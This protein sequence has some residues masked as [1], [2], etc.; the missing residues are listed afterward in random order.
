MDLQ[1]LITLVYFGLLAL[2]S[3]CGRVN[4]SAIGHGT[5]SWLRVGQSGLGPREFDLCQSG[6]CD[7]VSCRMFSPS[8]HSILWMFHQAPAQRVALSWRQA[9]TLPHW[10]GLSCMLSAAPV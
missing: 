10:S 6:S 7:A 9:F 4:F 1:I 5:V 3:P 8:C 2:P